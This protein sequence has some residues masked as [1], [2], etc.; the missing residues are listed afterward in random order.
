MAYTFKL[1]AAI[2]H[3]VS[4]IVDIQ[5]LSVANKYV[6]KNK[7]LNSLKTRHF[8]KGIRPPNGLTRVIGKK[9]ITTSAM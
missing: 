9:L 5:I 4:H 8:S 6:D 7:N 3:I 2:G 1:T